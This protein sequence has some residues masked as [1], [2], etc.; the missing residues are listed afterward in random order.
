MALWCPAMRRQ[1]GLPV[2]SRVQGLCRHLT[3]ASFISKEPK[4]T[5]RV[6][7]F[8]GRPG[9]RSLQAS[10]PGAS[11]RVLDVWGWKLEAQGAV[12]TRRPPVPGPPR[13]L[14]L[15]LVAT[16][17]PILPALQDLLHNN[18]D[19][20]QYYDNHYYN[21]YFYFYFDFCFCFYYYIYYYYYYHHC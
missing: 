13:P 17:T 9:L 2:A 19:C 4:T 11:V 6:Q 10:S 8:T 20:C 1:Q 7:V 3:C 5:K 16:T 18:Y 21:I 14:P 12:T 15:L